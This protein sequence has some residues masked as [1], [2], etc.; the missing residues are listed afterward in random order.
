MTTLLAG[1]SPKVQ[2]DGYFKFRVFGKG[3]S[4]SIEIVGLSELGRQQR[5]IVIPCEIRGAQVATVQFSNLFGGGIADFQSETLEKIF[6]LTRIPSIIDRKEHVKIFV[7]DSPKE[8]LW[9]G[10]YGSSNMYSAYVYK[11][12]H[13]YYKH[14]FGD[15]I[16]SANITYYLNHDTD[17]NYGVHWID[18][19]DDGHVIEFAPPNPARL[20]YQFMGW[21]TEPETVNEWNFDVSIVVDTQ[22]LFAKWISV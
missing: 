5:F 16:N 1:C 6:F 18:D 7:I 11:G 3:S 14:P 19:V 21:F 2:E 13:S 12:I 4:Q 10:G 20:G 9:W 8:E 22:Q 17:I 15:L